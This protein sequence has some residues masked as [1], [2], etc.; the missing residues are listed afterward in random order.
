MRFPTAPLAFLTLAATLPASLAAQSDLQAAPSTRATAEVV[1][2]PPGGMMGNTSAQRRITLNYGQPHLRGRALHT[3]SLVPFDQPWR[4]GANNPTTLS[5]EVE[6]T[7]GSLELAAGEYI[8]EALPTADGWTLLVFRQSG[9][10]A[11][12]REEVGQVPLRHRTLSTPLESLSM[13]LIPTAGSRPAQGELRF[14]WSNS[15]LS[16]DWQVR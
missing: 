12:S 14:A 1:L 15:E 16:V 9:A 5:S 3:D 2:S 11:E 8:L 6:L 13:W 7:L 4:L 10:E